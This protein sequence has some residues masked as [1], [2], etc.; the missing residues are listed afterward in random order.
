[1][2]EFGRILRADPPPLAVVERVDS[3]E[4]PTRGG[5][6]FTIE[7]ST[8]GDRARTL[9]S[10]DVAVCRDCR[11]EMSDPADRRYRHPFITCTHCGPR[12]TIVTGTPYDRS[13]T[14]MA[15]FT[16]C[17]DCQAEYE[18]PGDRRFHAQPISC[19]NC[20]PRLEL[21]RGDGGAAV[22]GAD[23]L[24]AARDLL[25]A[26][27]IVA[28]KGVGGY[29]LACDAGDDRAVGELRRRKERGG[30]PF[31]VMVRDLAV[32]AEL[33]T[34][35]EA[36]EELLTGVRAP[37]VLLPRRPG[38]AGVCHAVAPDNPDLGLMLPYTPLHVLLFGIGDDHPGPDALVMTSANPAGEPIVTD[39]ARALTE[40]APLADAWLRHDRTIHVPCDDSVSRY[41]AGAELPL[42]RSRGYAPLPLVLPFDVPPTLAVGADLKNTCALGEGRYA[43]VSQHIGDMAGLATVDALTRTEEHLEHLT[44]VRPGQLVADQHPDYGSARWARGHAAGRRCAPCSTTTRTSPR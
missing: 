27:R 18:D 35:T 19:H 20:G 34:L 33:V 2:A 8:E 5:T 23:A 22:T 24:R 14:T 9:V 39:D 29:H 6:E 41:A 15:A 21:V 28:V 26:G 1:M 12:F 44:G 30:K 11:Q 3:C 7:D 40:L 17:G 32:A 10:P 4:L 25:A 43:W 42:R 16:M 36:E 37:I 13:A 38:G 31:A